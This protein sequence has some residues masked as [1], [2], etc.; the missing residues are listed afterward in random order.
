MEMFD[1]K[2]SFKYFETVF[3]SSKDFMFI[4]DG[5]G[6]FIKTTPG[7]DLLLGYKSG[8]LQGKC[9]MDFIAKDEQAE[10]Y[11]RNARMY[12]FYQSSEQPMDLELLNKNG[13]KV[14]V[15][16]HCV[17]VKDDAG[18]I[19]QAIVILDD[20]RSGEKDFE[21]KLWESRQNLQSVLDNS[22]DG[23]VVHDAHGNVTMVNDSFLRMV[24]FENKDIIGKHLL[25]LSPIQGNYTT[26]AGDEVDLTEEYVQYHVEKS[27]VLFEEGTVTYR[28]YYIRKDSL[29]VPVEGTYSILYDKAGERRGSIGILRDITARLKAEREI[30]ESRDFLE[31]IFKTSADGIIVTDP[32]GVILRVNKAIENM[33]GRSQIDILARNT[34]EIVPERVRNRRYHV[35]L[36]RMFAELDEKGYV[37]NFRTSFLK[38]DGSLCPVELNIGL[39]RDKQNEASG[40]VISVRDITERLTMEK[41]L[42]R[43]KRL[44]SVSALAGGIA[45]DFDGMLTTMLGNISIAQSML[46]NDAEIFPYLGS[47]EKSALRAKDLIKQLLTFSKEGVLI[48]KLDSIGS[49]LEEVAAQALK[50]SEIECEFVIA[51]DLWP[52][53]FDRE[54]IAQVFRSLFLNADHSMPEG[55][56]I[57]VIAENFMVDDDMD[58]PVEPGAYIKI[59]LQDQG[60]GVLNE[61]IQDIFNPYFKQG[62]KRSGMVLATAYSIIQKHNGLI[63]VESEFGA[64]TSFFIYLPAVSG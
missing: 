56:T 64:G 8:A 11:L 24:D 48:K 2:N 4:V 18:K 51:E 6:F 37:D 16:Q 59:T 52:M 5:N 20:L 26:T 44:E 17:L 21:T 19:K 47:A 28:L 53:E 10:Q 62:R 50:D 36:K 7:F 40:A 23:I 60:I 34:S 22:G 55:G 46:D 15:C 29:I 57:R 27:N 13:K 35:E 61:Y 14:P 33:L 54:Q 1:E 41:E 9:Y 32:T 39:L 49:L 63:S 3:K 42:L 30:S 25:D 43:S 38:Q 12:Y 45:N 31:N 58:L